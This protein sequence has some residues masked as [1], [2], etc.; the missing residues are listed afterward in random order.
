MDS[1]DTQKYVELVLAVLDPVLAAVEDPQD[2]RRFLIEIGYLPPGQVNAFNSLS[3]VSGD[4][5]SALDNL[6]QATQGTDKTAILEAVGGV[7]AVAGEVLQALNQL[8]SAI[9]SN[10]AGTGLLS[11]TDILTAIVTKSVDYV[12]VRFLETNFTTL[13]AALLIV[14]VI[15]IEEIQDAPTAFHAPYIKRTVNWET[16]GNFFSDPLTTLKSGLVDGNG[17]RYQRLIYFLYMLGV[18]L[19]RYAEFAPPDTQVLKTFN[20]GNDLTPLIPQDAPIPKQDG[21]DRTPLS[22]INPFSTLRFPLAFNPEA[23]LAFMLYPVVDAATKK[24]TGVGAGLSFGGEV[25]IPLSDAF[26]ME[27]SFS[28]NLSDSLGIRLDTEGNFSFI[29]KIFTGS[30]EALADAI[31]FDVKVGIVPTAAGPQTPLF[32]LGVPQGSAL[33]IGSGALTIGFSKQDAF[34]AYLEVDLKNVQLSFATG[35]ADSFLSSLLP[36]DGTQTNFDFGVGFSNQRGLYF[37]GASNFK[38]RLPLHLSLGPIDIEYLQI[39]FGFANGEFPLTLSTGFSAVIGPVA[40][41]VEGM[42]VQAIFKTVS[43]NTGSFGPLDVGF[44]FKFPDGLGL[45]IDAGAVSGGGFILFDQDKGEYGGFLDISIVDMVQVK[46]IAILDTKLP[47]GSKGYSFIFIIFLELPPIQLGYGFTLTGVGG[48]AGINRTMVMSAL[49]AGVYNHTLEY[50]INPPHTVADAPKVINAI[51]SFFP[52]AI[53]RYV[54]GPIVAIGWETFVQLT[55]GV[56]LEVPDPIRLALLGIIDVGLPDVE[57]PDDTIVLLH[58]LVLGTIDFGTKK[59]AIDGSMYGSHIL[60]FPIL[61]DFALRT[62]WGANPSSLFSMGGFNPNFLTTGLDVPKLHRLSISIGDGDNPQI[63][64]NAYLA[65]T[66][67]TVQLGANIE[68]HI[69]EGNFKVHGYLGFDVL[70]TIVPPTIKCEFDFAAGF[71]VSYQGANLAG[72]NLT[73]TF[74]GTTPWH[75][76]GD[77]TLHLLCFSVSKT[78]DRTWGKIVT[79]DLVLL[80]VLLDLIPAL[81]DSRNWSAALPDGAGPGATL[82]APPADQKIILVHPMGTLTSRQTVVPFDLSITHY[83]NGIPSDGHYFSLGDVNINGVKVS[84]EAFQDAFAT[85]QFIDLSDA[86]KL[87]RSSFDQY[88]AGAKIASSILNT[89]S[90]ATRTVES[91][92]YYL[93]D[94]ISP[95][96]L[97]GTYVMPTAVFGVLSQPGT[98]SRFSVKNTGLNKYKTGP[99]TPAAIA[100]EPTYVVASTDD[101]SVRSDIVAGGATFYQVQ[102]A[103]KV[104]L[105]ANPEDAGKLQILPAHEVA[106]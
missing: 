26:Q 3:N 1:E 99:S 17:I 40:A 71:D 73:G 104:H 80:E 77:A 94:T 49:Q 31:N 89:G 8:S 79:P 101:L 2:A 66:S 14:G 41:A 83:K 19:D 20:N 39:E 63:S 78:V 29:N 87:N 70:I 34:Q 85:G 92:E 56:I 95:L 4:L 65:L 16:L 61:G 59:L 98:A 46:F 9:Q 7:L 54:F 102:A 62:S 36:T 106:S 60:E 30:S 21:D 13:Y 18:G 24:Y 64:A 43:D 76:H 47:D 23:T 55:V 12:V 58:I 69:S 53:G 105:A 57:E 35:E 38:I 32:S 27:I 33:Q 84:R 15:D 44:G 48:V 11:D 74:T 100:K 37:K 22:A 88:N 72:V 90:D 103:L 68:A 93:D 25:Q 28:S 51:G 91:N 5:A 50:V 45:S 10:F 97:A 96:R 67:N 81:T 86:D 42:G 6:E 52:P 75:L 82:S